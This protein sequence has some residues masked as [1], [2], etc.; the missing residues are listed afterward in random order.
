M[1]SPDLDKDSEMPASNLP[2]RFRVF[3]EIGSGSICCVYR[4]YDS[5][6][7][8]E[9]A[10]KVTHPHLANH[11]AV[12]PVLEVSAAQR[13]SHPN[14]VRVHDIHEAGISME[15][16][17]GGTLAELLYREN[18]LPAERVLEI[19]L[20]ISR[21]LAAAHERRIVHAD[22]KPSN[23]LLDLDGSAKISDFGLSHSMTQLS[24]AV[25]RSGTPEY[26]S[27][28]QISGSIADE[29]SDVFALG[30][31]IGEMLIGKFARNDVE[32]LIK[33]K[34]RRQ[35]VH[36]F[37]FKL[38]KVLLSPNP[39]A[40]HSAAQT[41]RILERHSENRAAKKSATLQFW[42][43][44]GLSFLTILIT[45][46]SYK[47][48]NKPST[49][50]VILLP[51][52][53]DGDAASS[54][55]SDT[56]AENL[57]QDFQIAKRPMWPSS[58]PNLERNSQF[59]SLPSVGGWVKRS[60]NLVLYSVIARIGKEEYKYSG[61]VEVSAAPATA[62]SISDRIS[63]GFSV[64]SQSQKLPPAYFLAS[65]VLLHDSRSVEHLLAA[66]ASLETYNFPQHLSRISAK[67]I[68][69]R[70]ALFHL[71]RDRLWLQRAFE[72]LSRTDSV[73][74]SPEFALAAAKAYLANQQEA[75]ATRVIE[76]AIARQDHDFKLLRL[77]GRLELGRGA[78]AESISHL[79]E[80]A[81]LNPLDVTT[82]TLLGSAYI[83]VLDD[84]H[85]IPA[86]EAA[87]RLDSSPKTWSNL[88]A[89]YM[90]GGKFREAVPLFEKTLRQTTESLISGPAACNL[91]QALWFLG[92]REMAISVIEHASSSWHSELTAGCLAHAYRWEGDS[93]RARISFAE[94]LRLSAQEGSGHA[95]PATLGRIA[96]YHAALGE[97]VARSEIRSARLMNFSDIDLL[98]KAAMIEAMLGDNGEASRLTKQILRRGAAKVVENNP[99]I[100]ECCSQTLHTELIRSLRHS[101]EGS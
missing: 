30:L 4:A 74:D 17:K 98:L 29:R 62:T 77:A 58:S 63:N 72:V 15:L 101:G 8:R 9:I 80:A 78:F 5:M 46:I 16:V 35:T 99:D 23:I 86:F 20:D 7:D 97:T 71:T 2:A 53:D 21:G 31:I 89:A 70:L 13:I 92:H 79:R 83:E 36:P 33:Q 11:V 25:E 94:A 87:V 61:R 95:D 100:I 50:A 48:Y 85:A 81:A 49:P 22:L 93:R 27:P 66:D 37:F 34:L 57:T 96:T 42:C 40:R 88:G 28:E 54:A 41:V 56:V 52:Q 24:S 75:E 59:A 39:Q 18:V 73:D 55:F 68:E 6:L 90:F 60:G 51:L 44:C 47:V 67:K 69:L 12:R 26:M 10:L 3:E 65:S 82:Q 19:A 1:Y 64:A 14:V 84:T 45:L 32:Y 91:G 38:I 76:T 43:A